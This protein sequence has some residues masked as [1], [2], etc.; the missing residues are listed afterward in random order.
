[1]SRASVLKGNDRSMSASY[2]IPILV[3]ILMGCVLSHAEPPQEKDSV[4]TEKKITQFHYRITPRIHSKGFFTYGG[5]VGTDNPSF[6]INFTFEYKQWGF[7]VYKGVDL[8]DHT[9]DYNFSLIA[10]FR[11]FK[12]S[13]RITFTPYLGTV[14]EQSERFADSGSDAAC[15]LVTSLKLLPGFTA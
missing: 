3:S 11:N 15:I 2:P 4:Q 5:Q 6:D 7:L 8:V 14:L 13:D 12:L 1:M 10:L 9:T